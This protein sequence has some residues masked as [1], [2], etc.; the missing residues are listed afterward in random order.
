MT[1]CDGDT[2]KTVV[3]G[4]SNDAVSTLIFDVDDTLYDIGCGFSNHRNQ[5]GAPT[6]I[7]DHFGMDR[8]AALKIRNEYFKKYHSTA[9]ALAVAQQ[10]GMFGDTKFCQ[11]DL[12]EFF[13]TKLNFELLGGQK[14]QL[15]EDLKACSCRIVAFSNGPRKYV[16]RVLEELGLW[17][18]FGEDKL[19]AVTDTLPYCK[20]E[21]EAFEMIFDAL[22]IKA[23]EAIMIE[24]SMKNII[25]SKELG[26]RTIWI[27]GKANGDEK[28]IDDAPNA[29]HSAVDLA[30]E[31]VEDLR[32]VVPGLWESPPIFYPH[33]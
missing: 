11:E 7:M 32:R 22:G 1:D 13:A 6:F 10:E 29:H 2:Q 19:F 28:R 16:K 12:E 20:P 30:I 4:N 3:D 26:L 18:V 31:C 21:K 27:T 14:K 17:E 5:E 25:R 8:D 24:D 23:E 15:A 33:R 9:K